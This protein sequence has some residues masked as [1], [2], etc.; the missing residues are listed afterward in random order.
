MDLQT[1]LM[2]F[3]STF[4][5]LFAIVDPVAVIPVYLSLTDR[6]SAHERAAVSLK[7]CGIATVILCVFAITGEGIFRLFG[8]SIPA[9]RIAGGILLLLLGI[10]QLDAHRERVK[11]EEENESFARD[12]ISIFPLATPL[13][14]GPG[15]IST[16][17]LQSSQ[18][19]GPLQTTLLLIAILLV[20]VAT[21][22]LLKSAPHLYRFLGQTGINLVTRIMG[23]ILTAIA[24]QFIIDGIM[25]V[26]SQIKAL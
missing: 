10:A 15:S 19:H 5:A 13:L 17:V 4:T 14:A 6:Y 26:I 22:F 2:T 20:F 23:I 21:Y 11:T 12:D 9:F 18:I 24:I 7:A 3:A 8:I 16:V 1:S 25:G